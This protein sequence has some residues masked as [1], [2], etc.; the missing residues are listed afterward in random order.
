VP[1]FSRRSLAKRGQFQTE[2]RW[3]MECARRIPLEQTFLVPVRLEPCAVPRRI[4]DQVQYVDLFPN[5]ERGVKRLVRAVK[6][7]LRERTA[8][9]LL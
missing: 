5:W 9:T 6:R 7:S 2:L 3:A 1:C 8:A 4:S